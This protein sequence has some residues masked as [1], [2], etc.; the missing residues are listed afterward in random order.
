MRRV[1]LT[2]ISRSV[3]IGLACG[4]VL[5]ALAALVIFDVLR[6]EPHDRPRSD[7][8]T[9][10]VDPVNALDPVSVDTM[11][12]LQ[13]RFASL[14]PPVSPEREKPWN[15]LMYAASD[16]ENAYRPLEEFATCVYANEQI[17]V[18]I[19]DDSYEHD[20]SILSST[21]SGSLVDIT[22][23]R[24]LG[25]TDTAEPATLTDFLEYA[26]HWFPAERTL[27]YVYGHGHGWWGACID[28]TNGAFIDGTTTRDWLTPPEIQSA[29][30]AVGG[31]DAIMFAAPCATSALEFAYQLRDVVDL[32]VAA[33]E[34][35]DY[36]PWKLSVGPIAKAISA[37]PSADAAAL[38]PLTI[39]AIEFATQASIDL[40][41][42]LTSRWPTIAATLTAELADVAH[43]FDRFAEALIRSLPSHAQ[44]I[45]DARDR[46]EDFA[47]R[48]LVD[49][50]D[51][52]LN[53]EAIPSVAEAASALTEALDAS[54]VAQVV[55]PDDHPDAHGLSV[56]FPWFGPNPSDDQFEVSFER[57]GST[58]REY[59]LD[60][61]AETCWYDFLAAF[62]AATQ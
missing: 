13:V 7:G 12:P 14:T 21:C 53:C 62:F 8:D 36:T 44:A 61:L 46:S 30:R 10:A 31:V 11:R 6:S 57:A 34:L 23:I 28:H 20:A 3:W 33:E 18:L 54:V 16:F 50:C 22:P 55:N 43:T 29:L 35:S 27:L 9:E 1:F 15:V 5:A 38:G 56:Y 52:A 39:G 19:F 49:L 32:F 25:E 17:N 41:N 24:S 45:A 51:F 37:N 59:G 40:G 48:E 60:L 26:Q 4:V 58:Y 47:F 42:P 2:H